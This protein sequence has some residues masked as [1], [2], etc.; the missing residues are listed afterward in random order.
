MTDGQSY[1]VV[2][3]QNDLRLQDN[4]ALFHGVRC[5]KP[6]AVVYWP[7]PAKGAQARHQWAW[8]SVCQLAQS[9]APYGIPVVADPCLERAMNHTH[10]WAQKMWPQARCAG[11]YVNDTYHPIP[12]NV[13]QQYGPWHVFYGNRLIAGTPL[14]FLAPVQALM[15]PPP[16]I[17][18]KRQK[19]QIFTPFWKN[20]VKNADVIPKPLGMPDWT[21]ACAWPEHHDPAPI[22]SA[23]D[24]RAFEVPYWWHSIQN[25]WN[26]P[27][28]QLQGLNE[29][30]AQQRWQNFLAHHADRYDIQRNTPGL[31]QGTAR[32]SPYF[33]AGQLSVRQVWH[34]ALSALR[35]R[36]GT[37]DD[38]PHA[39]AQKFLTKTKNGSDDPWAGVRTFLSE[40]GWREFAY[41]QAAWAPAL[42]T[43]PLRPGYNN[44]FSKLPQA[45]PSMVQAWHQG[46]T[47]FPMVDAGMRQLWQTG[48]MHN[49][50]RMVTASLAIKNLGIPWTQGQAWFLDTLVDADEAVN[51]SSWQWVAG[52]GTDS[53]PYFRIFNPVLQAKTHDP[54]QEYLRQWLP[55]LRH[56]HAEQW[57]EPWRWV[58]AYPKPIVDFSLT[59]QH[60]MAA[61][62][63]FSHERIPA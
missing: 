46:R 6:T 19:W 63:T 4:P 34:D 53:A 25:H 12:D 2:I 60:A 22:V 55:E 23:H 45:S 38:D 39:W 9:L 33:H 58:S 59:R 49:R 52:C 48:W 35:Q 8:Q 32:L 15:D 54:D 37:T 3:V 28:H 43:Q 57:E 10:T 29:Q 21:P 16:V 61:W 24:T 27:S 40:I 36:Y 11:V 17:A 7:R 41:H 44:L 50:V 51:A 42:Q 1:A 30:A 62:Q 47:G 5:Q 26:P 20:I 14:D 18:Q 31:T 13:R 56:L